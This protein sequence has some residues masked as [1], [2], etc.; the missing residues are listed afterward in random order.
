MFERPFRTRKPFLSTADIPVEKEAVLHALK[1]GALYPFVRPPLYG[2]KT[3]QEVCAGPASMNRSG[4]RAYRKTHGPSSKTGCPSG[5]T[6]SFSGQ[7][8]IPAEKP[9]VKHALEAGAL[10]P[11]E[12]PINYGKQTHAEL[13]RWA[14]VW[15]TQKL[16]AIPSSD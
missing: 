3:H 11:G 9:A 7:A 16:S 4:R 8:C 10:R 13:C 15:L 1:T 14:G 12:T 5:Q 2:K 6:A